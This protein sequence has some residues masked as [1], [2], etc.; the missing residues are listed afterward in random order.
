MNVQNIW[1]ALAWV[2]LLVIFTYTPI[3]AAAFMKEGD[4]L[5]E[6]FK[7]QHHAIALF[8]NIGL[9]GMVLIDYFSVYPTVDGRLAIILSVGVLALFVIYIHAGIVFYDK[10]SLYK[11][12]INNRWLSVAAHIVLL[13]IV[14]F[15]KFLSL[16]KPGPYLV[17]TEVK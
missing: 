17:A 5:A 8:V 4:V 2:L 10:G 13:L 12:I 1:R 16:S 9:L 11:G 15:I 7:S 3:V 6:Y 14:G